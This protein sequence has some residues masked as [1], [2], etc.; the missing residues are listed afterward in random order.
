MPRDR[1]WLNTS[2]KTEPNKKFCVKAEAS[3]NNNHIAIVLLNKLLKRVFILAVSS[4]RNE[5]GNKL[6]NINWNI[7]MP[8]IWKTKLEFDIVNP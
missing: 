2:V 3:H 1:C 6:V 8:H 5:S 7:S 4:P